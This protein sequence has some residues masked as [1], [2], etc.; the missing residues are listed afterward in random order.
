MFLLVSAPPSSPA[1]PVNSFTWQPDSP[2]E[3]HRAKPIVYERDTE[4]TD[5]ASDTLVAV[6]TNID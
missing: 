6:A 3:I 2:A 1:T 5:V 4:P